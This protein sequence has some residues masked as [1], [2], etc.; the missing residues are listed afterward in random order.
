MPVAHTHTHTSTHTHKHAHMIRSLWDPS[1]KLIGAMYM[2]VL[3]GTG[4]HPGTER[5]RTNSLL[6]DACICLEAQLLYK[7]TR[8]VIA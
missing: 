5:C 2:C 3:C 6:M 7:P 1:P 4:T 8:L